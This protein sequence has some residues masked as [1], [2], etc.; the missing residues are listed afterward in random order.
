MKKNQK[1]LLILLS[2]EQHSA[3][4]RQAAIEGLSMKTYILK[5]CGVL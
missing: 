2:E 1:A 5:S 4:K 3:L